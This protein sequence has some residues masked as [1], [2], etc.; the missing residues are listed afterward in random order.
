M[1][2]RRRKV[3]WACLAAA[4]LAAAAMAVAAAATYEVLYERHLHGEQVLRIQVLGQVEF[5]ISTEARNPPLVDMLNSDLLLFISA[6]CLCCFLVARFAAGS[7]KRRE[8]F[9]LAAWLGTGYL[10][11]D[12]QFA[13]HESIGHNLGFLASLPG[14]EHPDDAVLLAYA[15][16]IALFVVYFRGE[17]LALRASAALLTVAFVVSGLAVTGDTTPLPAEEE[18]ELLSSLA[19]VGAFL[20]QAIRLLQDEVV[21]PRGHDSALPVPRPNGHDDAQRLVAGEQTRR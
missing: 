18:F 21:R 1:K 17:I 19:L 14:I 20:V 12:E 15:V 11:L 5:Y 3:L 6:V 16:P 10:A 2:L 8:R 9:F 4:A 7:R 13:L